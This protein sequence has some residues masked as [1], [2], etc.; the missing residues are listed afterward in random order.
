MLSAIVASYDTMD[1]V[2]YLFFFLCSAEIKSN[3]V[4]EEGIRVSAPPVRT[5]GCSEFEKLNPTKARLLL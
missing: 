1:Y 4:S 3:S 5:R 2:A